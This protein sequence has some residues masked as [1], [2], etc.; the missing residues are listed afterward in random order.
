MGR[1]SPTLSVLRILNSG[2]AAWCWV[3]DP[4]GGDDHLEVNYG[5][6]LLDFHDPGGHW[7]FDVRRIDVERWERLYPALVAPPSTAVAPAVSEVATQDVSRDAQGV[8]PSNT[9]ADDRPAAINPSTVTTV[10]KG[11]GSRQQRMI[12]QIAAEEFPDGYDQIETG[13]IIHKVSNRL[14]RQKLHVPKRD[15]FLRALGRRK[16]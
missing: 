15:V 4:D 1:K 11:R 7:E 2:Q 6:E 13:V 12:Q 3:P 14:G 5:D 16:D 8:D 9:G 10:R